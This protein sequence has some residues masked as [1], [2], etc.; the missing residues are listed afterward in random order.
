MANG[1]GLLFNP[2]Q[3]VCLWVGPTLTPSGW[4]VLGDV[5]G[6]AGSQGPAGPVGPQGL[7]GT[8]GADGPVG[9]QGAAGAA[10]QPG[11]QGVQ[12]IAGTAGAAGPQGVAGAQGVKGDPG[13]SA[14]SANAGNLAKLGTDNLILVPNVLALKGIVDLGTNVGVRVGAGFES[15]AAAV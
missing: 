2:T 11:P 1:Q 15:L 12:G 14:V 6:P 7:Q 5:Q 9:P 8:P 10:G 13:P 3:E 4:V